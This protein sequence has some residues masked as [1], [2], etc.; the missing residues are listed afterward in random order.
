MEVLNELINKRM[1]SVEA[2]IAADAFASQAAFN[3]EIERLVDVMIRSAFLKGVDKEQ[4]KAYLQENFVM[5]AQELY[6]QKNDPEPT[7][8]EKPE[9]YAFAKQQATIE[10]LIK[11]GNFEEADEKLEAVLFILDDEEFVKE[12]IKSG[13]FTEKDVEYFKNVACPLFEDMKNEILAQPE[14]QSLLQR[15]KNGVVFIATGK[16]PYDNQTVKVKKTPLKEKI[17]NSKFGEWAKKHKVAVYA[18]VAALLVGAGLTAGKFFLHDKASEAPEE[19]TE[20]EETQSENFIMATFEV[21]EYHNFNIND[22]VSHTAKL[23]LLAKAMMERGVP[24]VSEEECMKLGNEGKLAVSPEQLNNWLISI[25]LED[26]DDLTFTKLLA[27][28]E[29]DKEELSSDFARVSNILGSIYTTKE[30]SPFI[31]E[32]IANKEY[33]DYIKTYEEAIIEN[34]KGHGE[35]LTSLIKSRVYN[36]VAATSSGALSML[37]TALIYQQ[38][39]VYNAQVVGQDIMDLYN[40]N[41]ECATADTK[42]CFYSDDWAEYMRKVN[43]KLDAVISYT[44]TEAEAYANYFLT[45]SSEQMGNK[46]DIEETVLPYLDTN[47]VQ[48][49]EWDILENIANNNTETK[50]KSEEKT[51]K[52]STGSKSSKT[53]TRKVVKTPTTA[54]E[55]KTQAEVEAKLEK[56]NQDSFK[57]AAEDYAKE[58]GGMINLTEDGDIKILTPEGS[59]IIVDTETK[60]AYDPSKDYKGKTFKDYNEFK[61]EHR[62]QVE[63]VEGV[64][65]VVVTEKPKFETVNTNVYIDSNGNI[66]DKTTGKKVETGTREEIEN[67][68]NRNPDSSKWQIVEEGEIHYSDVDS[69]PTQENKDKQ[70][71]SSNGSQFSSTFTES[72]ENKQP[73]TQQPTTQQPTNTTPENKGSVLDEVDKNVLNNLTPEEKAELEAMLN[74]GKKP[75]AGE[76]VE[77]TYSDVVYGNYTVPQL[78]SNPALCQNIPEGVLQGFPDIWNAYQSWLASQRQTEVQATAEVET[79]AAVEEISTDIAT[80]IA[81]LEAEKAQL[82]ETNE[83]TGDMEKSL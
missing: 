42:T 47:K 62:G 67:I 83:L 82:T 18:G 33:S 37:S 59:P 56:E 32:F 6:K 24:V 17:L 4:S 80:Q 3:N 13:E 14:E 11:T 39:N 66:I 5:K 29:T 48:L 15:L 74:N 57:K 53:G 8:E 52:T 65:S 75:V 21:D 36:P 31:Y 64:G 77:E 20:Q 45:L 28:S 71:T 34:Q 23:Q 50:E 43:Q 68:I 9:N 63:N 61:E 60:G 10:E 1:A 46:V 16:N 72:S 81:A 55:K 49:G 27:D 38:A 79:Q 73:T 78:M 35:A 44:G 2:D 7:M 51:K 58:H 22:Q 12:A 69:T 54:A 76:I 26:M 19:T 40:I 30:S 41:G 70:Y 25:N